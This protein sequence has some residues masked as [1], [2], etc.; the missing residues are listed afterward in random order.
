[1]GADEDE[2]LLDRIFQIEQMA[3]MAADLARAGESIGS[4]DVL[5]R[6]ASRLR[7]DYLRRCA[8]R[9]EPVSPAASLGVPRPE[10]AGKLHLVIDTHDRVVV[11]RGRQIDRIRPQP[12]WTLVLLATAPNTIVRRQRPH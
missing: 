11:W 3:R 10:S 1:M 2:Q 9:G 12:F 4:P 8:A 5:R 6:Q 7:R